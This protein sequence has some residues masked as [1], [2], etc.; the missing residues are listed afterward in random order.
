MKGIINMAWVDFCLAYLVLFVT[1]FLPGFLLF[2]SIGIDKIKAFCAAPI[3]SIVLYSLAGI[4][5]QKLGIYSSWYSVFL[6]PTLCLFLVTFL[7][8][9]V[10]ASKKRFQKSQKKD[11]LLIALYVCIGVVMTIF[12]FAGNLDG[13]NSFQPDN[14][15]AWHL[16]LIRTFSETGN[17]S[18]LT[19]SIYSTAEVAP[20]VGSNGGYYPAAM[21][22][23]AASI[24][25]LLGVTPQLAENALAAVTI[26]SVY[27]LGVLYLLKVVSKNNIRICIA[28][29]FT[30][31]LVVAFPWR[32][33]T[34]GPLFPNLLSLSMVPGVLGSFVNVFERD[35]TK[36]DRC[37][38]LG[39]FIIG[40][41]AIAFAH[42]NGLFSVGILL[43]PFIMQMLLSGKT[44]IVIQGTTNKSTIVK[45]TLI[46]IVFLCVVLGIWVY[47]YNLPALQG[48]VTFEWP[49]YQ[50]LIDSIWD[51]V[52][53]EFTRSFW[54][55]IVAVLMVVGIVFACRFNH[56][57]LWFVGAFVFTS[58]QYCACTATDGFWDS[59]LCGFWYTDPNRIAANVVLS[60]IPLLALG[61]SCIMQIC[62]KVIRKILRSNATSGLERIGSGLAVA[63]VFAI[64]F[65]PSI[66]SFGLP[67]TAFLDYNI[68]LSD[69]YGVYSIKGYTE[70]E[71]CFVNDA[72]KITGKKLMINIP[73][74]G[75][76][77]AYA[78][79]N[80]NVYYRD[81]SLAGGKSGSESE[82]SILI[83]TK[84]NEIAN[85]ED[86]QVAVKELGIEYVLVLDQNNEDPNSLDLLP[87]YISEVWE[88][89]SS[90]TDETPGFEVVLAK[91]D[92]RLY[93]ICI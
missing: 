8:F 42:P 91:D 19:T 74:D 4:L 72:Q 17:Y 86:V 33:A 28:G 89:I 23:I 6:L 73:N 43:V 10:K 76:C 93:R 13:P 9:I 84:L 80:V 47:A 71:Q 87:P 40:L 79:Q 20:V 26:S 39:I 52:F 88:G 22:A 36:S 81:V 67:Y 1:I 64:C 62:E 54:E 78:L 70:E 44:A 16:G 90:I 60:I 35:L 15:N 65:V 55:P 83:R 51:I 5:Y 27:P 48:I 2:I 45:K 11:L 68:L 25:S 75:S 37:R 61:L 69:K 38:F 82:E 41:V 56:A 77:F 46:T 32:F 24:V 12:L 92:M 53:L 21:H 14:D 85:N 18:C 49:S 3:V 66:Y 31:L 58:I 34:W 57:F 30:C 59:F 50:N 63:L 7:L 29:A